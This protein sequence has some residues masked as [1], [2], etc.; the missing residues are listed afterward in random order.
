MELNDNKEKS[1]IDFDKKMAELIEDLDKKEFEEIKSISLFHYTNLEAMHNII[2]TNTLWATNCEYLN[3]LMELKE[4]D[5]LFNNYIEGVND[6]F[7]LFFNNH[8]N[9][10]MK[11]FEQIRKQT[12]IISFANDNNS[13]AM[14]RTYGRNGIVLEFDT[15]RILEILQSVHLNRLINKQLKVCGRDGEVKNTNAGIYFAKAIYNENEIIELF[16][17]LHKDSKMVGLDYIN[18][19]NGEDYFQSTLDY[20]FYK[21][22]LYLKDKNFSYEKECR[23]AFILQDN[24]I[25]EVENFRINN[26]LI[27][28]YISIDLSGGE[29]IPIKSITIN[30][31]QKDSMYEESLCRLLKAYNY[32]IPIHYADNKIR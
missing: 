7:K 9:E 15:I 13:I 3:D 23:L 26:N 12:Y 19:L 18:K 31:E 16:N 32:N 8:K 14:W 4:M 22:Y 24:C 21:P 5:N 6:N 27:I 20:I 17:S 10:A 29:K 25:K 28:P 2:R 11:T 30:P 1:A